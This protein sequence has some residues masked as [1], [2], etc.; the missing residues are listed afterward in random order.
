MNTKSNK[1]LM[2]TDCTKCGKSCK[3]K[4]T[5]KF[6]KCEDKVSKAAYDEALRIL[7]HEQNKANVFT[8]ITE[9]DVIRYAET[10]NVWEYIYN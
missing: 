4:T 8:N 5:L 1:S 3:G 10:H 7:N 2:C 6:F 9:E